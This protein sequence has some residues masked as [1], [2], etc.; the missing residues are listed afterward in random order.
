MSNYGP[1]LTNL[2]M[3]LSAGLCQI[4]R[5]DAGTILLWGDRIWLRRDRIWLWGGRVRPREVAS[6]PAN[7]IW[8]WGGRIGSGEIASGSGRSDQAPARSHLAG[9]VGSGPVASGSGEVGSA[10]RDRIW[11]GEAGSGSARSHLALVR[12]DRAP[13]RSH[14]ALGRSHRAPARSHMALGR[15]HLGLDLMSSQVE[16][17]RLAQAQASTLQAA[18]LLQVRTSVQVWRRPCQWKW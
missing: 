12:S 10:R 17:V 13:A 16:V 3:E 11:L 4:L 18:T 9:E 5:A 14:L 8:L 15:S 6:G 1:T 2:S 7:R